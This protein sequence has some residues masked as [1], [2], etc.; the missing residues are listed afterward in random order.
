MVKRN[1]GVDRWINVD[2]RNP[3]IT[4]QD[5]GWWNNEGT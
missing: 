5:K 1:W 4:H 3:D 2:G